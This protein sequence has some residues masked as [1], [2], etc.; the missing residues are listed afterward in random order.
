MSGVRVC[1]C[2]CACV[3]LTNAVGRH[4]ET[5]R[6]SQDLEV[7]TP[8]F[9]DHQANPRDLDTNP[10]YQERG[11][12]CVWQGGYVYTRECVFKSP[13]LSTSCQSKYLCYVLDRESERA[14]ERER[15]RERDK[16]QVDNEK[17]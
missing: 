12:E 2:V 9:M 7:Q 8:G 10:A 5:C 17:K 16:S 15:E 3:C 1:V 13:L 4:E 11:R 6:S 14:R